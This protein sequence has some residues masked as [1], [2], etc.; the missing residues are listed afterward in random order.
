MT[1]NPTNYFFSL[2]HRFLC[3]KHPPFPAIPHCLFFLRSR[4]QISRN[5]LLSNLVVLPSPYF[6]RGG[7][8]SGI[9]FISTSLPGLR[10]RQ[11]CAFLFE[12][13]GGE[14]G[15]WWR[16]RLLTRVTR[17]GCFGFEAW[18]FRFLKS[19]DWGRRRLWDTV[20]CGSGSGLGSDSGSGCTSISVTGCHGVVP[21][22]LSPLRRL[23]P[24]RERRNT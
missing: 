17:V 15:G 11:V 1:C 5:M 14:G 24:L 7:G 9:R 19:W 3:S 8:N 21:I 23:F 16:V 12:R 10:W 13:G 2:P 22:F 4:A 18:F 20:G 6:L